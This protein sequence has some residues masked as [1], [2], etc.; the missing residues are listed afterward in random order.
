MSSA[1]VS[2]GVWGEGSAGAAEAVVECDGGGECG[3]AGEQPYAEVGEGAGAVTLEGEDV[4]AGLEDRLNALADRCEVGAAPWLVFAS[5]AH[6]LRVELGEVGLEVLAAEVLIADQDE[7]L[8]G[9]ALTA[10]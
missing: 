4:L 8:P 2:G 3:E 1:M 6:D 7:D 5:G 10:R 9:L